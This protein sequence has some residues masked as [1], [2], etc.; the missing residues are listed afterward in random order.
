MGH[1]YLK[2]TYPLLCLKRN[3][4]LDARDFKQAEHV[5]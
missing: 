2:A 5:E 3:S 4:V 1:S